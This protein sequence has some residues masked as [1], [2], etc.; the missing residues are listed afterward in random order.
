MQLQE[1]HELRQ[2]GRQA[3]TLIAQGIEMLLI[4]VEV[5]GARGGQAAI[6]ALKYSGGELTPEEQKFNDQIDTILSE[7][8]SIGLI[9]HKLQ[10]GIYEPGSD[11]RALIMKL[12]TDI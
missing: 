2:R 12:R 10:T 7:F 9:T 1:V 11:D 8:T 4:A 6:E 5:H 3:L